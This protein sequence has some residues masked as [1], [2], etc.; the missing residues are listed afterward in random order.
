MGYTPI[1]NVEITRLFDEPRRIRVRWY[2]SELGKWD[3]EDVPVLIKDS[4]YQDSEALA[5]A[6]AIAVKHLSTTCM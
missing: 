3:E 4:C 5:E 2:N 6:A 1:N